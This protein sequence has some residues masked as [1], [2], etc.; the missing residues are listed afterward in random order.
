MNL[1]EKEVEKAKKQILRGIWKKKPTPLA[2]ICGS[3]S[4]HTQ[5]LSQLINDKIIE[6]YS[7]EIL[8]T[9]AERNLEYYK[10]L[11][12]RTVKGGHLVRPILVKLL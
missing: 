11:P 4:A 5:A 3:T 7:E 8:I 12:F 9:D 10:W 2:K 1:H 6:Q